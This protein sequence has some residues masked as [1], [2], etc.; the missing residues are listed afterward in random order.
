MIGPE[1]S[2]SYSRSVHMT[3]ADYRTSGGREGKVMHQVTVERKPW[4]PFYPKKI[5]LSGRVLTVQFWTPYAPLRFDETAVAPLPDG[6]KG[7]EL[8]DTGGSGV[9]ITGVSLTAGT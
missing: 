2:N 4:R 5:T 1:Y 7:F 3:A 6:N 8:T 9:T